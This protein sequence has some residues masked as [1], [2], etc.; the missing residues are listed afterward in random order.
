MKKNE[1]TAQQ[2]SLNGRLVKTMSL[3]A[4]KLTGRGLLSALDKRL[5][6]LMRVCGAKLQ[7]LP[8]Q[9]THLDDFTVTA[10][11]I[12]LPLVCS[13]GDCTLK[14]SFEIL[15]IS[16]R[17]RDEIIS[18]II[19]VADDL[20][21]ICGDG[22]I[23]KIVPAIMRP[24]RSAV[25]HLSESNF[26][27]TNCPDK[28]IETLG[29]RPGLLLFEDITPEEARD[30]VEALLR[31][32]ASGKPKHKVALR[33]GNSNKLDAEIELIERRDG[34]LICEISEAV[35]SGSQRGEYLPPQMPE[36]LVHR[37]RNP[38]TTIMS[39][40]SQL[41]DT[42]ES[43]LD[44]ADR[45]LVK[46]I[47]GA[48]DAQNVTVNRYL[49]LYGSIQVS[50]RKIS[51]RQLL[52]A[53]LAE[54]DNRYGGR[55]QVDAPAEDSLVYCD[56]YLLKQI[57]VELLDNAVEASK[58]GTVGLK[59]GCRNQRLQV[60]LRNPAEEPHLPDSRSVEPFHTTKSG[61][62]GLGLPLAM[63][64]ASLLGGSV[65]LHSEDGFV[66]TEIDLPPLENEEVTTKIERE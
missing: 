9:F 14:L 3:L 54:N 52:V 55:I 49:Q 4:P 34:E 37:L 42:E 21:A 29:I 62:T 60:T 26:E 41:L 43:K 51:F 45:T 56:V 13:D 30:H 10:N 39:C 44:S 63:R 8:R 53:T 28:A 17:A 33:R 1:T 47:C 6:A 2:Q 15:R 65:R 35:Q 66:V 31:T 11:E 18:S 38:L 32:A 23:D 25:V 46:W 27:V 57:L 20:R 61:H 12:T 22:K 24:T 16:G 5:G 36:R 48:A 64:Y 7:M 50:P 40:C 59:W 58:A 19:T